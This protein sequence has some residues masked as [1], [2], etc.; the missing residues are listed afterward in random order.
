MKKIS[1]T[2][3]ELE[4][5]YQNNTNNKICLELKISPPTLVNLL[6]KH[7]IPLKGKGNRSVHS[8]IIISS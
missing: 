2:V 8:K 5:L 1:M 4:K 3:E 7:N 6:K